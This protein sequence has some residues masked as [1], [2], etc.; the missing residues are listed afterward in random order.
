LWSRVLAFIQEAHVQE[1]QNR[2]DM[3]D[4]KTKMMFCVQVTAL[5][6]LFSPQL[7]NTLQL[8][9]AQLQLAAVGEPP[10]KLRQ[11]HISSLSS[12][13]VTALA[14]TD[15]SPQLCNTLQLAAV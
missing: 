1:T 5:A 4:V 2:I 8:A 15:V 12:D 14:V 13:Q 3:R 9:A 7:C 11:H 6:V 10:Q